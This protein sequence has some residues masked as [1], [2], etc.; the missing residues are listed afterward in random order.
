MAAAGWLK[1]LGQGILGAAGNFLGGAFGARQQYRNQRRLNE[2]QYQNDVKMMQFMLDYNDPE[3]QMQRFEDAGLNPHLVYGQ[4]SPGNLE[5]PPKYPQQEAPST[6]HF[7][8]LG[9]QIMQMKLMQSQANLTDTKVEESTVKQDLMKAQE[10]LVKANPYLN[11]SYVSAMVTNLQSIANVKKQESDFLTQGVIKEGQF[12]GEAGFV[13]MRYEIEQL[14]QKF[15]LNQQDQQIKGK[16]LQSKEFQNALQ[17][18]QVDWMK[19]KE[20]T[21]QHIYQGIIM[22]LSKMM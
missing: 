2:Q 13:K 10:N 6:A 22:L 16:I 3:S 17:E 19:N 1:T 8:G 21:P 14:A 4:G 11:E 20:I 15:H 9:S 5:S 7:S 18:I 12:T